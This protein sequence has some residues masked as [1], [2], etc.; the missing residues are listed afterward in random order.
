MAS[1]QH[2]SQ[3]AQAVTSYV[4]TWQQHVRAHACAQRCN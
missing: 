4:P 3:R 2:E 1:V